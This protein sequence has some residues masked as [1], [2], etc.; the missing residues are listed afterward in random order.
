M[1]T[2]QKKAI[3]LQ[4]NKTVGIMPAHLLQTSTA[5]HNIFARMALFVFSAGK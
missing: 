5:K 2:R 3:S 1:A 4:L